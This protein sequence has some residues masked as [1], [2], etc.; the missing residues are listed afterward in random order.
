MGSAA[1]WDGRIC[2]RFHAGAALFGQAVD[3]IDHRKAAGAAC[4]TSRRNAGLAER[5]T[6]GMLKVALIV[7]ETEIVR[8]VL[9]RILAEAG[10]LAVECASASEAIARIQ[11]S[12][13]DV[14]E[15]VIVDWMLSDPGPFSV[16]HA[17]RARPDFART[18]I[19]F[20][21]TDMDADLID[22]AKAAGASAIW[23]KPYDALSLQEVLSDIRRAA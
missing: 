12:E 18:Q 17:V 20:G 21:L 7:D 14:P 11:A 13:D 10:Y 23:Q 9:V 1:T 4:E 15:L 8:A 22:R 3:L 16:I 19:I 6:T 2:G 5:G